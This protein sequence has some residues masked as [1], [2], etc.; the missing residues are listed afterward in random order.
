[1]EELHMI[2]REA[3]DISHPAVQELIDAGF[4]EE[5]SITAIEKW[6][7]PEDAAEYL[8]AMR[9]QSASLQPVAK[10]EIDGKKEE[11]SNTLQYV[12]TVLVS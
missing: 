2:T 4:S 7:T 10:I 9:T 8:T 12:L 6:G 11:G 5:E 1:M 3:V